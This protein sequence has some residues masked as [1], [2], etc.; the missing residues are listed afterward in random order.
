M[1]KT[2]ESDRKEPIAENRDMGIM[3]YDM[4]FSNSKN[5]M[6][7][8]YRAHMQNGVIHV[9]PLNSEEILR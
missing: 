7:M 6:P 8:F 5:T 4:D 9:P 3:L 2:E 1:V